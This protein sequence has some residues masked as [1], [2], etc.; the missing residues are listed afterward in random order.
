MHRLSIAGLTTVSPFTDKAVKHIY[1]LTK[2]IPRRINLLCDRALLGAY[3]ENKPVI[4]RT[5]IDKAAAEI[6]GKKKF[7]LLA[8]PNHQMAAFSLLACAGLAAIGVAWAMH[9]GLISKSATPSKNTLLSQN[10]IAPVYAATDMAPFVSANLRDENEA[11]RQLA[12][13]WGMSIPAGDACKIAQENSLRC[14]HGTGGLAEI[15]QIDRPV[16][17]TLRDDSNKVY[18][19]L[20]TGLNN[21]SA[22]LRVGSTTKTISLATLAR[23]FHGELATFWRTPKHFREKVRHGFQGED[24]NW[25]DQQ[26]AK[27]NGERAP[28]TRHSYNR[29]MVKQVQDFQNAR[30]V[31]A[32]G[33]VGPKTYMLINVASGISEPRLLASGVPKE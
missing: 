8:H 11:Y 25:L 15:K 7:F 33:V 16:I 4:D 20:L 26:L 3:A 22:T 23:H 13:L 21:T 32:D 17:L 14:Y 1:R 28:T 18:Y 30:G 5:I 27:I 2:G 31:P 10:S 29:K 12:L 24:V 6:F 19:A 9:T